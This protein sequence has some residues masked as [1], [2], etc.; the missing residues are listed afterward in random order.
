MRHP[1]GARSI[2]IGHPRS[3]DR[4]A[5][6]RLNPLDPLRVAE[7][8]SPFPAPPSGHRIPRASLIVRHPSG[9]AGL[10]VMP[11]PR[12]FDST[13]GFADAY[14]IQAIPTLI[15]INPEGTIELKTNDANEMSA[16]IADLGL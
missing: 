12:V 6:T 7:K 14:G 5:D 16:K 3:G 1:K 11:G 15:L 9:V 13:T 2:G 4:C 8:K 10:L